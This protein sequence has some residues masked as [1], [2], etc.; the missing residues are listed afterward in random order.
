MYIVPQRTPAPNA[1]AIPRLATCDDI[2]LA[3]TRA[4]TNPPKNI[5]V[6]P[7]QTA[8]QRIQLAPLNSPKNNTPQR[9]PIKA[10]VFH[11]GNAILSP[12]SLMAKMVSVFATD[13]RQPAIIEQITR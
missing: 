3:D 5:R 6:A 10:L 9:I 2:W 13:H 7:P 4:N 11:R 12:R 1:A 8:V